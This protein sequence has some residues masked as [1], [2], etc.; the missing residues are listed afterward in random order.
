MKKI[1]LL[2]ILFLLLTNFVQADLPNAWI[3]EIHYDN[4]GTDANELVEIVIENAGSYSLADFRV[5]LYNGSGG[6]SYSVKNLDTYTTGTVVGNYSFFY[7]VYPA[8]PG[9]QNG[10]PDGL[11]LDYLGTVIQFLSYEG[12]FAAT[13]SVALGLTSTD[14]GVSESAS[15][16]V[17]V[18]LQL[19]GVNG[20]GYS[21]FI[22]S[23]LTATAGALNIGQAFLSTSP[24]ITTN[25]T[26]ING[27]SYII[28][29][30]P[31][32]SQSFTVGGSNLTNMISVTPPSD[33]EISINGTTYQSAPIFLPQNAGSVATTTVYVRLKENL[34]IGNYN[35]QNITVSSTGATDK[36][37][38]CNGSVTAAPSG[39]TPNAWINEIHYDNV[40]TD[41]NEMIEIVIENAGTYS[42]SDFSVVLYNGGT[43][44]SYNTTALNTFTAGQVSGNYSCF[45]YTYSVDGIQNGAPDGMALVYNGTVIQFI[46][47]EGSFAATSGPATGLTSTDIIVSENNYAVGNSLQLQGTGLV[48]G[49]F[50]W[51]DPVATPGSVNAYQYFGT[52][53]PPVPVDW[54]YML[55]MFFG[56]AA[57]IIYRKMIL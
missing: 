34:T 51:V 3:N 22:W 44:Q 12:S 47:Y 18:S 50:H 52:P 30:G 54:R 42:L 32:T 17:G 15:T 7:F 28:N 46:S 43:G 16:E 39:T 1:F 14:I 23:Y 40:G 29:N 49:D 2:P 38:V 6:A 31:S 33:Y 4:A 48:Y 37:V 21:S 11:S 13:N 35:L 9:I 20:T 36:Y 26:A 27:F 8:S 45:H 41:V 55:L 56:I 10:A 57:I 24:T 53:P 5:T 25:V 19:T